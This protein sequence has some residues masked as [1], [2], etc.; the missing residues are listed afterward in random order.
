MWPYNTSR[1]RAIRALAF[2][3]LALA[4]A[5]AATARSKPERYNAFAVNLGTSARLQGG[6]AGV[7]QLAIERYST[8]Q[9]KQKL[10]DAFGRGGP[11][12]L[13]TE[14]RKLPR[15]GY[16]RTPDS[17]AWD[18]RYASTA[19]DPRGGRR[20]FLLTDRPMSFWEVANNARTVDY[21]F[22]LIEM[23]IGPKGEGEGR[24]SLLTKIDLSPDRRQI[25]LENWA[26]EP[27]RLQKIHRVA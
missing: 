8:A 15:V 11:D 23:H 21:P 17:I 5:G 24:M 16:I 18:L 25:E 1:N 22:T 7:V 14:L 9:E 4:F 3:V 12:A 27:V 6:N 10:L 2:A 19:P 13:L 20:V 26:S